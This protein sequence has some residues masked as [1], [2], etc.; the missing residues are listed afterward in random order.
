MHIALAQVISLLIGTVLPLL[1]GLVTKWN[2]DPGVRAVVLLVLSAVSS[3]GSSW[4]DA[5][6]GG[7]PFDAGATLLAVLATFLIGV[8]THFGLWQPTGLAQIAKRNG[9]GAKPS[10]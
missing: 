10:A 1:V 2:A 6:N 3:F 9:V 4:L 7:A 5:A 8:G